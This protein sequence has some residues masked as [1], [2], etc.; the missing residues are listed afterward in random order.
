MI[1]GW[2]RKRGGASPGAEN[3]SAA[4][5]RDRVYHVGDVIGGDVRVL[6]VLEGGLGIVYIAERLERRKGESALSVLKT[7]NMTPAR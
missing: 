2:G 5:A 1:F 3:K 4:P 6:K 7:P